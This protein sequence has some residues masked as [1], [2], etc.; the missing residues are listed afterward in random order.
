M[1]LQGQRPCAPFLKPQPYLGGPVMK[2]RREAVVLFPPGGDS[3][4]PDPFF[5]VNMIIPIPHLPSPRKQ[6][7]T[8]PILPVHCSRHHSE[9]PPVYMSPSQPLSLCPVVDTAQGGTPFVDWCAIGIDIYLLVHPR[10]SLAA[11]ARMF[12]FQKQRIFF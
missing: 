11:E 2:E 6:P 4:H 5:L 1:P 10:Y 12:L 3:S 7:P 9:T 8:E